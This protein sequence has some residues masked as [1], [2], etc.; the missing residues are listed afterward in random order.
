MSWVI[1]CL[2]EVISQLSLIYIKGFYHAPHSIQIRVAANDSS[3]RETGTSVSIKW[4]W[5]VL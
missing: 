5:K 1:L 3:Y 4:L 2:T